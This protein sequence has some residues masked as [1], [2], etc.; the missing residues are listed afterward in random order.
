[1]NKEEI[2]ARSRSEA[3]DEG[4]R[5]AESRGRQLGIT[6]F[7]IMELAIV[8]FNWF[9]GVSNYVPFAMLWIFTGAEAYPKY[10]FT[11]KKSYLVT[12]VFA[13][14]AAVLFLVCHIVE[15]LA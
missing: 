5:E 4:L 9:N 7:G 10:K 8:V 1:M 2:L 15:L 11:Q 13:C 3:V 6:A 14:V 12:T